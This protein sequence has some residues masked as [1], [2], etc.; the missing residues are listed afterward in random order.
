MGQAPVPV[1]TRLRRFQHM[2]R[3]ESVH[4]DRR[5][6]SRSRDRQGQTLQRLVS[7][8]I[9]HIKMRH[10]IPSLNDKRAP[11]HLRISRVR[12]PE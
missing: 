5:P 11:A 3:E 7:R 8:P 2:N 6:L 10:L 9:L 12:K 1:P 4:Q